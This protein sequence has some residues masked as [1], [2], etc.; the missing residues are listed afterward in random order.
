MLLLDAVFLLLSHPCNC[1]F[2]AV[3]NNLFCSGVPVVITTRTDEKIT[4]SLKKRGYSDE[5]IQS[6]LKLNRKNL[7]EAISKYPDRIHLADTTRWTAEPNKVMEG[8]YRFLGL[9]WYPEYLQ[10]D[11][12]NAK[13][14]P[15][16]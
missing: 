13:R 4:E 3:A 14:V 10:M 1:S 9:E 11:A 15:G 2:V 7:E 16:E 12:F 8:V 6:K 5:F